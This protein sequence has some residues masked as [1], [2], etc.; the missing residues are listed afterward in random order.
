M[1]SSRS[2][3]ASGERM[4]RGIAVEKY[5]WQGAQDSVDVRY[6]TVIANYTLKI[7]LPETNIA[8][9]NGWLEYYFPIGKAY[10]QGL[11]LLVS[12]SV[13][14]GNWLLFQIG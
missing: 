3:P 6:S 13:L 5:F 2:S 9:K 10:F 7:T 12:G 8:P 1:C 11:L 14:V 4:R